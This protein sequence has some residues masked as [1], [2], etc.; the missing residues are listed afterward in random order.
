MIIDAL[1]FP[2]CCCGGIFTGSVPLSL[3]GSVLFLLLIWTACS[4]SLDSS[5]PGCW[6]YFCPLPQAIHSA[7][8]AWNPHTKHLLST[9][10][11]IL[12]SA[13]GFLSTA[14]HSVLS[15]LWREEITSKPWW[16]IERVKW[17]CWCTSKRSVIASPPWSIIVWKPQCKPQSWCPSILLLLRLLVSTVPLAKWHS[18]RHTVID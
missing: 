2:S 12:H 18:H 11:R 14:V 15:W 17:T 9:H 16:I 5:L 6:F 8:C 13:R 3:A 4:L 10:C 7:Y 1:W